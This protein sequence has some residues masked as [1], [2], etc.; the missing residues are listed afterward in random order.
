MKGKKGPGLHAK[1]RS[2]PLV[3][4][5]TSD[6]AARLA[7]LSPYHPEQEAA[8][9]RAHAG[10]HRLD[11]ARLCHTPPKYAELRFAKG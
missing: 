3:T 8:F 9:N 11:F 1:S 2:S 7:G 10:E 4:T 6:T 5:S